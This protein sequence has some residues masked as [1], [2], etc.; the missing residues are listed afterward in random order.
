MLSK[1]SF[2]YLFLASNISLKLTEAGYS[3]FLLFPL[4]PLLIPFCSFSLNMLLIFCITLSIWLPD[5]LSL[6]SFFSFPFINSYNSFL[7]LMMSSSMTF[8][9]RSWNTLPM[10]L[11]IRLIINFIASFLYDGISPALSTRLPVRLGISP[12]FS[13]NVSLLEGTAMF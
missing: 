2:I 6:Y 3:L 13:I 8:L 10:Y 4:P 5:D 11:Y 1:V 12:Y 7:C 9:C